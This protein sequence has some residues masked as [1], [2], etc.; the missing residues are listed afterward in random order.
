M[1]T[2]LFIGYTVKKYRIKKELNNDETKKELFL[3]I[4]S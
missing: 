3:K 2:R 4:A 1:I